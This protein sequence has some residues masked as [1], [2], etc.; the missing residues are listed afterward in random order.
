MIQILDVLTLLSNKSISERKTN[1]II[2]HPLNKNNISDISI[3]IKNPSHETL[4]N[5]AQQ[6]IICLHF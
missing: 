4:V 6:M 3:A 1:E 2:Y 5:F